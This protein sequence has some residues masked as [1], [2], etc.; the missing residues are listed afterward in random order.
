MYKLC[1][2]KSFF[3]LD[4]YQKSKHWNQVLQCVKQYKKTFLQECIFA[5]RVKKTFCGDFLLKRFKSSFHGINF[6][7]LRLS[8]AKVSFIQLHPLM[9]N[10]A[11]YNVS[12]ILMSVI[13]TTVLHLVRNFCKTLEIPSEKNVFHI[14]YFGCVKRLLSETI[15]LLNKMFEFE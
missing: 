3:P 5:K 9:T 15:F 4:W 13:L 8:F 2:L 1:C 10:I 6:C 7:W 14:S 11:R 12:L